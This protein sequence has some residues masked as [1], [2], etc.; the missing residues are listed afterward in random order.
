MSA[1]A[2]EKIPS[3]YAFYTKL[4][5]F[6]KI[7]LLISVVD[8]NRCLS[9]ISL[10]MNTCSMKT[11]FGWVVCRF[12]WWTFCQEKF[13]HTRFCKWSYWQNTSTILEA[14]RILKFS[15]SLLILI[16]PRRNL[17]RRYLSL[18]I[19]CPHKY[20]PDFLS[21]YRQTALK[22]YRHSTK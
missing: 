16:F 17:F 11:I 18:W 8:G 6:A 1:L 13:P 12:D 10:D 5:R 15:L 3:L 4:G 21:Y 14:R 19:P 2:L 20:S 9:K 22:W 7:N